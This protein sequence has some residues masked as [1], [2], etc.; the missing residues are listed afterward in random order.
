MNITELFKKVGAPLNNHV[1]SWGAVRHDGA[2]FLRVWQDKKTKIDDKWC[3]LLDDHNMHGH[4]KNN[5]G[6]NERVEHVELIKDGAQCYMVMCLAEDVAAARRDIR[7]F[8]RNDIFV[9]GKLI[10]K[11]GNVFIELVDRVPVKDVCI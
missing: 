3:M 7:S 5:L 8:N 11:G 2:V 1:W 4:E 6:Y 9:G 10:E